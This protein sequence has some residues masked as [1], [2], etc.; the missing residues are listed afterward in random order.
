MGELVPLVKY[1]RQRRIKQCLPVVGVLSVAGFL[2]LGN[3]LRND[4]DSSGVIEQTV[5]ATTEVY[6]ESTA[7][8]PETT[9][10]VA[11]TTQPILRAVSIEVPETIPLPPSTTSTSTTSTTTSTTSTTTTLPI[12]PET[13]VPPPIVEAPATT[14]PPSPETTA[15]APIVTELPAPPVINNLYSGLDCSREF[16]LPKIGWTFEG[17]AERCSSTITLSRLREL[18]SDI[19]DLNLIVANE[20]KIYL[21]G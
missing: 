2:V 8:I 12:T 5:P 9:E 14:A 18:N 1:E 6:S 21:Q 19:P 17:I 4:S 3:Q 7:I 20:T 15:P 11:T 13:T 16:V 10:V